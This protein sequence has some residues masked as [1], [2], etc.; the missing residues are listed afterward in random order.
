MLSSTLSNSCS[1][2]LK[3]CLSKF[4]SPI[5]GIDLGTTNSCV[6]LLEDSKPHVI[7]AP[8]GSRTI[9]S[10]VSFDKDNNILVGEAA[11]KQFL[12]NPGNT[13]HATKRLIGRKFNDPAT[14]KDIEL[15]P[16]KI[17]N[18]NGE[19][20]V[21]TA[22]GKHG[23]FSPSDVASHVL[24]Y[25]K[26]VAEQY[27][28][29]PVQKAIITVPA[30][31]NDAQRQAT[32]SAGKLAG[33]NVIRIIN[34]PTAASLA[35][36]IKQTEGK[37][38]AVYDLGGGTFDV[39]ILRIKNGVFEVL[40]TCGDTFLGGED[41]DQLLV[42]HVI[43]QFRQ[44]S[45][46][47][48]SNDKIAVQRVREEVERAKIHLS[49]VNETTIS[50][51]FIT[52][53]PTGPIH[54][55]IKLDR[56][57]LEELSRPLIDR[58]LVCCRKAL[59]DAKLSIT[60]VDSVVLVGGMTRM[61]A[62]QNAIKNE[63]GSKVVSFS[64]NPDEAVAIGAAILGGVVSGEVGNV[65]LLDVTPLSLGIETE[66]GVFSII[67][68]RNSTLPTRR[69]QTFSTTEDNQTTVS[70]KVHQGEN[71]N[72]ADNQLLGMFEVSGIPP[73]PK[74]QSTIEVC[75]DIDNSGVV[76]VTA[77]DK[78]SNVKNSARVQIVEQK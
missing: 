60:D 7:T 68:P 9:P 53:G 49:S 43:N 12:I 4:T 31:F 47:S 41:F 13:F 78:Q 65:L 72:A 18:H 51:P 67:I 3:S 45:T 26:Q 44:Q 50:V 62:V 56:S 69:S 63:L 27:T 17:I 20:W 40:S 28:G 36:G 48:L 2:F 66:G 61:P 71:K 54:L 37:T 10:M 24:K 64:V 22:D 46:I 14:K 1:N 33:L 19:A 75:F 58:T 55:S 15:V 77:V 39:S 59:S 74:G 73:R 32:I 6:A 34:E 16:Y 35:Y 25:V 70:I 29:S 11:K 57:K 38:I 52:M 30:Y 5:I 76:N 8:T 21:Q 23:P 42:D